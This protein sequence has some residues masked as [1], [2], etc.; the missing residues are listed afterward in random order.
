MSEETKAPSI[1]V[2]AVRGL[3]I[4]L[5]D[6]YARSSANRPKVVAKQVKGEETGESLQDNPESTNQ[7]AEESTSLDGEE[8]EVLA[9][10]AAKLVAETQGVLR[11]WRVSGD[12]RP[13]REILRDPKTGLWPEPSVSFV[14]EVMAAFGVV[15][16][17]SAQMRR[18]LEVARMETE[19]E[20]ERMSLERA[21]LDFLSARMRSGMVIDESELRVISAPVNTPPTLKRLSMVAEPVP[22]VQKVQQIQEL[23]TK[24]MAITA[25]EPTELDVQQRKEAVPAEKDNLWSRVQDCVRVAFCDLVWCVLGLVCVDGKFNRGVFDDDDIR[26]KLIDCLLEFVCSLLRCIAVALCP[27][28]A[29]TCLPE[30]ANCDFA[31]EVS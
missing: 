12:T 10:A 18:E 19:L 24:S 2:R 14:G 3:L 28:E 20:K 23:Q 4:P 22:K 9:D 11:A 7:D 25:P 17:E 30:T 6:F 5:A 21:R 15:D 8:K 13:D 1:S 16:Q 31:V 29:P 27:P 26:E